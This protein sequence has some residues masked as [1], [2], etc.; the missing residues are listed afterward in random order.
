MIGRWA[1]GRRVLGRSSLRW[2]LVA[3]VSGVVVATSAVIFV[4][5]YEQTGSELRTQIDHDVAGDVSALSQAVRELRAHSPPDSLGA[6]IEA[7]LRAQPFTGASSLLFA[8]IPGYGTVC[9]HPELFGSSQPD[10]GENPRRAGA[11]ERARDRRSS[12]GRRG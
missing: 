10:D 11:R 4:V 7:Y 5:V 12:A 1:R 9:N 3:W 6:D 2:R 8:V